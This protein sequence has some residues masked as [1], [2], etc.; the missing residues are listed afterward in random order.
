MITTSLWGDSG[1]SKSKDPFKGW[2]DP[3]G[4]NFDGIDP[5]LFDD[6]GKAYVFNDGPKHMK[7]SITDTVWL[8]WSMMWKNDQVIPGSIRLLW[9]VVDLVQETYWI[10]A[11]H[12][13]KKNG[14]YHWCVPKAVP[15]I[16][17]VK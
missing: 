2:S 9:M 13:Y 12:I 3:I 4:L 5:Y 16:G 14:R 11:P 10:E 7:N 15:E 8:N 17:I 6:N 1:I